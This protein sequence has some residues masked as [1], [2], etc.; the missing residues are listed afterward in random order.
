MP[1]ER[2]FTATGRNASPAVLTKNQEELS[3]LGCRVTSKRTSFPKP[4]EKITVIVD[5]GADDDEVTALTREWGWQEV[6][7]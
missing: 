1:N 4:S 7:A 3:A 5:D 2:V 6:L